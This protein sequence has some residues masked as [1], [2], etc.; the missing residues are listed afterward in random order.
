MEKLEERA[1]TIHS[2][3]SGRTVHTADEC[4]HP[5][6]RTLCGIDA[7]D[8][9]TRPGET[10]LSGDEQFCVVCEEMALRPW[11]CRNCGSLLQSRR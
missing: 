3:T 5:Y 9:E 7:R 1:N 10:G 8:Y 4:C 2:D 11:Y 6:T